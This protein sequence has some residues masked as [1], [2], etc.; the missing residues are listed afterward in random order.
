LANRLKLP[1]KVYLL[2]VGAFVALAVV[3]HLLC[4][5]HYDSLFVKAFWAI[6]GVAALSVL[7][8]GNPFDVSGWL[9]YAIS[10]PLILLL[11][12]AYYGLC[13]MPSWLL[14]RGILRRPASERGRWPTLAVLV[15]LQAAIV[16]LHVYLTGIITAWVSRID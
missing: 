2:V 10:F 15:A 3:G 16:L 12:L 1:A 9:A 6:P 7:G 8:G 5:N 14:L 13:L 11:A 4:R